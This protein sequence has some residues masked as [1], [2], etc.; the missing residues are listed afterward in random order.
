MLTGAFAVQK[1]SPELIRR[2]KE[3][4]A[5]VGLDEEMLKKYPNQLSGGESQRVG[6]VRAVISHTY[7]LEVW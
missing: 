4:L 5:K 2:V 1:N 7:L 3:L 6:I